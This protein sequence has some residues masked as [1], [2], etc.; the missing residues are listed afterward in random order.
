MMFRRVLIVGVGCGATAVAHAQLWTNGTMTAG[1]L[2]AGDDVSIKVG[3]GST[4]S[5]FAGFLDFDE[6]HTGTNPSSLGGIQ[7]VCADLYHDFYAGSRN[8][9]G[10]S[11]TAAGWNSNSADVHSFSNYKSEG[12]YNADSLSLAG[13]IVENQWAAIQAM[14]TGQAKSDAA[15]GL[16][17]AVWD[18]LYAPL[19]HSDELSITGTSMTVGGYWGFNTVKISNLRSAAIADAETYYDDAFRSPGS[20]A[21][22]IQY[23]PSRGQTYGQG[24]LTYK[25]GGT[26]FIVPGTPGPVAALPFALGLLRRRRSRPA[27]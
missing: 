26:K 2:G 16:Q 14:H 24:Q 27:A 21:Y 1:L 23:T 17:V 19:A 18:A 22:Y 10:T 15:A 8:W 7:T 4:F 5:S 25:P 11:F 6:K 3:A 12:F 20:S 9:N 13:D